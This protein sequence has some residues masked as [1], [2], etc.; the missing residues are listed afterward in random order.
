LPVSYQ[1]QQRFE[2]WKKA[3]GWFG[4][5]ENQPR[6]KL[7]P[8]CGSLVGI[9]ATR[10]H[11]CGANLRFSLAALSKGLSGF[12]GGQAPATTGILIVNVAMFVVSWMATV[13][14]GEMGKINILW[15]MGGEAL[16]R[17]GASNP[18][19]IYVLHEWYRLVTAMFL[20]L[21]LLHIGMNMMVLLDI[22]PVV[23]ELYGSP[24]FLFLYISTGIAGFA[25]SSFRHNAAVGA[26]GA[27]MGIIGAMIAITTKR[28]GA[29]MQAL[30]GRLISW[31]VTIF[32]L[33]LL[34][35][36]PVDNWGHFGGLAAGF[37]IGKL[38]LDRL[39]MNAKE[40][41]RAYALGWLA[42]AAALA[43]FVLMF[44][45]YRDKLPGQDE[46]RNGCCSS[47]GN[48]CGSVAT[49]WFA[50]VQSVELMEPHS[51]VVVSLHTPKEKL[52][53]ELLSI[54][55]A[56]IT[57]RGIDLNSFDHFV[58]QINSADQERTG[59]PTLFFPMTRVERI[60]LDESSGSIPSLSEMFA[61]KTGQQ[62]SA[63]LSQ[64]A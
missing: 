56:G 59:L 16:Y 31:V 8:A 43:S 18:F 24:R 45:H 58:N 30:R 63:Y 35:I 22:G 46:S 13:G 60:A 7:C 34:R 12:F 64:F 28:S 15:G 2:R 62:I 11:E 53:G 61:R 26:S 32:A 1:W 39:P 38:F 50:G 4:G 10:C 44:L 49:E 55:A 42:G 48:G 36:V 14:T 9:R 51:I 57:L 29:S 23:E 27:I 52:W 40:R 21:G 37:A 33:G 6:P 3:T 47:H 20:H 5:G 25:L 54:H 41:N 17:L 19:G